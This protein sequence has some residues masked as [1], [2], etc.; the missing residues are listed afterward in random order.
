LFCAL[1]IVQSDEGTTHRGPNGNT[2]I[3]QPTD[4][5][6]AEASH[7]THKTARGGTCSV[8]ALSSASVDSFDTKK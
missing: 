1:Y 6:N 2:T 5:S 8:E 4:A 3:F 7:R